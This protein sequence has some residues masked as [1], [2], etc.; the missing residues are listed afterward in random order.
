MD[1][2]VIGAHPDDAEIFAGGLIVRCA[3]AGHSVGV[4]H[5]TRGECGTR[6]SVEER[7][8]E[9]A[10]SARI[11]GLPADHMR[12]LDLG[13]A[14]LENTESNRL[15]IIRVLREWRPRLVIHHDPKI[16]RHPD[17]GKAGALARDAV[18]YAR[19]KALDTGQP[20]FAAAGR[21]TFQYN[22][23]A[24][25]SPSVVADI[26]ETF[27]AKMEALRAYR[28]QF[29]NPS[30]GGEE[31]YISSREFMEQIEVRARFFGGLIGVRY[32]EPFWATA[33]LLVRNPLAF[34]P[35]V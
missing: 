26:T 20:P 25:V 1:C 22:G 9:A 8:T 24:S 11:L 30:Y 15:A 12:M 27:A 32:G 3:R 33:P 10:E 28:S 14:R 6:G 4:L 13:D 7:R 2:L 34:F 16:D 29:Y 5:L 21:M 31:T 23:P 18:F 17:H 35:E 19:L